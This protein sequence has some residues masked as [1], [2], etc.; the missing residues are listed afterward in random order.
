MIVHVLLLLSLILVAVLAG[1]HGN[2]GQVLSC[3]APLQGEDVRAG[4]L[5]YPVL[6]AADILLYQVRPGH[7][8]LDRLCSKPACMFKH[9]TS[10]Q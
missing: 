3:A 7:L 2:K 10:Q 5:T 1:Y 8:Q 4:L 9:I 6:M